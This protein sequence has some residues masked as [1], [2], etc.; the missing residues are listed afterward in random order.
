MLDSQLTQSNMLAESQLSMSKLT[1]MD[2][3]DN[4]DA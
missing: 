3:V 4:T 1:K 2:S